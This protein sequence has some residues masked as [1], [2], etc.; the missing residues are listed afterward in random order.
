MLLCWLQAILIRESSIPNDILDHPTTFVPR[1]LFVLSSS[2]YGEKK[3]KTP[4]ICLAMGV[5]PKVY[6]V[7]QV[8]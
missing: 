4:K 1:A 2:S 8:A 6:P 3:Q 5:P 7:R